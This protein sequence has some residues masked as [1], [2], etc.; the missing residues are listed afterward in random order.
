MSARLHAGRQQGV[1][2]LTAMLVVAIA[3][4]L[5]VELVWQTNLDLRRT[6]GLLGRDQARLY[7]IGAEDLAAKLLREDMERAAAEPADW[8][9]EDW[10]QPTTFSLDQGMMT[11]AVIDLQGRFNLNN[12]VEAGGQRDDHAYQQFQRLL[13][14]LDLDPGIADATIDWI[15]PDTS[16]GFNG[17]EDDV[18][19]SLSP[20]YRTANFWFTSVSELRAV[21]G[22]EP[23]VY[24]VLA[25]HLAALP[26][27]GSEPTKINV[28]TATAAVLQSLSDTISSANTEQWI[29]D[30][31]QQPFEDLTAFTGFIDAVT[32]QKYVG[33]SSDYFA[34]HGTVSIGATRLAMYSLLERN[35]QSVVVRLRSFD[36]LEALP[37]AEATASAGEPEVTAEDE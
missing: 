22:V 8:L 10:A 15:D 13:A 34:L 11:G 28:N 37:V 33:V 12:L 21:R 24:A 25:P 3:A 7:G 19:T 20:P 18:Y 14:V 17:A 29:T 1:A 26:R 6:E 9:G 2:V 32:V 31:M 5:A 35:G 23:E 27:R 16:A 36:A 4:V 30:R